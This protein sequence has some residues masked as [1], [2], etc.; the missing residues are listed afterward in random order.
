M[1]TDTFSRVQAFFSSH[2]T[3]P[4]GDAVRSHAQT[5]LDAAPMTRDERYS[6]LSVLC[7]ANT[8][9]VVFLV[10]VLVLQ[11]GEWYVEEEVV[12]PNEIEAKKFEQRAAVVVEKEKKEQ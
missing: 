8:I 6:H 10:G 12:K 2:N 3:G 7:A 11:V 4:L 5:L 9:A 1:L